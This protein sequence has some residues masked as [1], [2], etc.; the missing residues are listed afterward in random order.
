MTKVNYNVSNALL[1]AASRDRT[2]YQW[3][4]PENK[5][6]E[7]DG[8]PEQ[9]FSS[10]FTGDIQEPTQKLEG[11]TLGVTA[12]ASTSGELGREEGVV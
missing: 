10:S 12:L 8:T 9:S 2:I 4:W 3:K 11:H 6:K 5:E 7:V 1:H